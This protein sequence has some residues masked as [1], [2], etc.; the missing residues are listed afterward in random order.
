MKIGIDVDGVL[1]DTLHSILTQLNPTWDIA[2]GWKGGLSD[3]DYD[4]VWEKAKTIQNFWA[5]LQ[6]EVNVDNQTCALLKHVLC[7]H[8]VWFITNRFETKGTSP[9]KQTKYWLHSY[10]GV[11]SP[12]VIVAK[13]KGPVATILGLDYFID[14]NLQNC[15]DVQ[16]ARPTAKVFLCSMPHNADM[17]TSTPRMKDLK[18]FLKFILMEA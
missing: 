17:E 2:K 1:A 18:E 4:A 10:I 14:D 7:L 8:D 13:D 6:T 11:E 5:H 16:T 9:M 3:K 12:N 15:I